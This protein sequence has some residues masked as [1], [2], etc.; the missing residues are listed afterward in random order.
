MIKKSKKLNLHDENT[1][2]RE[3]DV[4]I[5][6]FINPHHNSNIDCNKKV[7]NKI[8]NLYQNYAYW[9]ISLVIIKEYKYGRLLLNK[10]RQI[11]YFNCCVSVFRV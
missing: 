4:L 10:T 7:E 9:F 1:C 6:M 3:T 8:Y 2:I 11:V 5:T